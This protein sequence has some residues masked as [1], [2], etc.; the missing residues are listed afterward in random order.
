MVETERE[1]SFLD[2]FSQVKELIGT[3]K[4]PRHVLIIPDGNRRW[5]DRNG[6]EN[7]RVKGHQAGGEVL[8]TQLE[9]L[10][11]LYPDVK[12]VT[13]W[14]FSKD[15][16]QRPPEETRP[17]M[18]YLQQGIENRIAPWLGKRN[19]RFIHLGDKE[20]LSAELAASLE[21]LEIETAH[22]DG[23]VLSLGINYSGEDHERRV[24]ERALQKYPGQHIKMTEGLHRELRDGGGVVP[25][26]D[27]IIRTGEEHL[28]QMH[29]S[30]IGWLNGRE[31]QLFPMSQL[32]P[33]IR[34][35]HTADALLSFAGVVR[36]MGK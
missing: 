10:N 36:N 24:I 28:P 8:Q 33:D 16:Q 18:M 5:A 29:T 9:D 15:N 13:A 4:L 26:A 35:T 25:P 14:V 11:E 20:S 2:E 31:T 30:D 1:K 12:F 23:Q 21:K 7:N 3:G 22:N 17:L 27:L 6:Y 34:R 32:Y 19:M